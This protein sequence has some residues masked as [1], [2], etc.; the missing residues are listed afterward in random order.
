[1]SRAYRSKAQ[2]QALIEEYKQSGL[3]QK[4]FCERRNISPAY[5]SQRRMALQREVIQ[6]NNGFAQAVPAESETTVNTAMQVRVGDAQLVLPMSVSP[7]WVAELVKALS[8]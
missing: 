1:M 8:V 4:D 3:S 7:R 6:S 2:W 5:F